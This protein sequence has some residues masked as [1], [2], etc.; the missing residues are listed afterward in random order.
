MDEEATDDEC[1]NRD[2][3]RVIEAGVHVAQL[4]NQVRS[5]ERNQSAEDAVT[6]VIGKR[7]RCVA[8]AR[9]EHF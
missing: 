5:N 6:D 3:H 4:S 2:R 9:R 1:H 8:N 7:H